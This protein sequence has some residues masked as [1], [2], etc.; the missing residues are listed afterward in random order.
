MALLNKYGKEIKP[1][2]FEEKPQEITYH[3]SGATEEERLSTLF[4]FMPA[5]NDTDPLPECKFE[6]L[7][8]THK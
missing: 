3:G 6:W 5:L 2:E 1:G 8:F 7:E 4:Q